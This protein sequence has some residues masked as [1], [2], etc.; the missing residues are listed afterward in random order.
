MPSGHRLNRAYVQSWIL[1]RDFFVAHSFRDKRWAKL[2]RSAV[3]QGFAGSPLQPLYMDEAPPGFNLHIYQD[4]IRPA[5]RLLPFGIYDL[6]FSRPNVFLELGTALAFPRN[7]YVTFQ[8]GRFKIDS[9]LSDL[10]GLYRGDCEYRSFND[11]V[12]FI[13][14][15]IIPHQ[16]RRRA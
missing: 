5:I 6:S 1:K 3:Q 15:D 13:R 14:R 11:L 4:Y 2:F 8:K 16:L 12:R 7:A 9:E 10:S